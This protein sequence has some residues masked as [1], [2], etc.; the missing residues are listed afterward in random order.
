MEDIDTPTLLILAVVIVLV[1]KPD[2][3]SS[4]F[5]STSSSGA[6]GYAPY[7]PSGAGGYILQPPPS[8]GGPSDPSSLAAWR[9]MGMGD[10]SGK[11]EK[12]PRMPTNWKPG[13]PI[14]NT[15]DLY[16]QNTDAFNRA[17]PCPTGLV[18]NTAT[19]VCE[20]PMHIGDTNVPGW[21]VTTPSECG[22]E[23]DANGFSFPKPCPAPAP[24]SAGAPDSVA[25]VKAANRTAG[26]FTPLG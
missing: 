2:L 16:K 20:T 22:F 9:A 24:R 15:V 26:R 21:S 13:Q 1:L 18:F 5:G 4:L 8:A 23:R 6:G 12:N 25:T 14:W 17:H 11:D 7:A 10:G 19:Q 3:L